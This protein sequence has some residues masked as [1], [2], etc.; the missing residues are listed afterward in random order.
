MASFSII[1]HHHN[2]KLHL[3][4]TY[5]RL[6]RAPASRVITTVPAGHGP[7]LAEMLTRASNLLWA[8]VWC[9][10]PLDDRSS[11][12]DVI[13]SHGADLGLPEV[14]AALAGMAAIAKG[15]D[16]RVSFEEGLAIKEEWEAE[17][18]AALTV[19]EWI[20]SPGDGEPPAGDRMEQW[21]DPHTLGR[22]NDLACGLSPA[23][24]LVGRAPRIDPVYWRRLSRLATAF[25]ALHRAGGV[26]AARDGE[27]VCLWALSPSGARGAA[28][29]FNDVA[30]HPHFSVFSAKGTSAVGHL[31]DLFDPDGLDELVSSLARNGR[32]APVGGFVPPL[33]CGDLTLDGAYP[34]PAALTAVA[35]DEAS[36]RVEDALRRFHDN[37]PL[38]ESDVLHLGVAAAGAIHL[39]AEWTG[40]SRPEFLVELD[41]MLGVDLPLALRLA[42]AMAGIA[43]RE[44][45]LAVLDFIGETD[46][47]GTGLSDAVNMFQIVLL[48]FVEHLDEFVRT[49]DLVSYF[50]AGEPEEERDETAAYLSRPFIRLA[51][52]LNGLSLDQFL[53][54]PQAV[55][56][57]PVEA[58]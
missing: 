10:G 25:H 7:R 15:S 52:S 49:D 17:V 51:C 2:G 5:F 58:P 50:C 16:P 29:L 57:A 19:L 33:D 30:V 48:G 26:T 22:M 46:D 1:D 39:G 31:V 44:L 43:H 9:G 53:P 11:L 14:T 56:L 21:L 23:D 12:R 41:S 34:G 35:S 6:G 24:V 37:E 38:T 18:M 8:T 42:A 54:A 20:T 3:L 40:L 45:A 13:R 32:P 28:F 55:A 4:A 47:G 36:E 27:S